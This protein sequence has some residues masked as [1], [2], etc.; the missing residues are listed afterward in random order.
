MILDTAEFDFLK[1]IAVAI[2]DE[3]PKT[4]TH[5]RNRNDDD[6]EDQQMGTEE[7]DTERKV[8]GLINEVS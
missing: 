1:E 6:F 2:E 5:K 4:S 3:V 7:A 8:S